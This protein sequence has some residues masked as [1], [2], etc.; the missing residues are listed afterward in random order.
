MGAA[1]VKAIRSIPA[2]AGEPLGRVILHDA[3]YRERE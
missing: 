2:H 3:H 1:A